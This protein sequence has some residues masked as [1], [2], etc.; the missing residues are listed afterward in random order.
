M[1]TFF[2][3]FAAGGSCHHLEETNMCMYISDDNTT[4]INITNTNAMTAVIV[5][6]I[7]GIT[8]YKK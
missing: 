2:F 7:R 1:V 3:V 6:N 5:G 8:D 4:T